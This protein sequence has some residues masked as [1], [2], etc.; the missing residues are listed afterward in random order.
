MSARNGLW[1]LHDT[2]LSVLGQAGQGSG[3]PAPS[4]SKAPPMR[5]AL[6][7]LQS[8]KKSIIIFY[9]YH[10]K[11]IL[12]SKEVRCVDCNLA[13]LTISKT[14]PHIFGICQTTVFSFPSGK[15]PI[16]QRRRHKRL[17]SIG[18]SGRSP[19]IGNCNPLQYCWLEN[20]TDRGAWRASVHRVA[21]SQTR[22]TQLTMHSTDYCIM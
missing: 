13:H 16:C 18:W 9:V 20:P 1:V 4:S 19:G 7:L 17:G 2:G 15:E 6:C 3:W 22:L 12:R 10:N 5:N 14:Y 8:I 21:K 11:K